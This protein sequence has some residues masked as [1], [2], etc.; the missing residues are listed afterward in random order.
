MDAIAELEPLIRSA[1]LVVAR[2]MAAVWMLPLLGRETPSRLVK[3]A[4]G[5]V[6]GVAV[7]FAL[8]AE[9]LVDPGSDPVVFGL[10]FG[11]ELMFGLL[12]G[13]VASLVF[14]VATI[15]GSIIA[16]EMGINLADQVDPT[17]RHNVPILSHL[18][19]TMAVIL[20][21]TAG[22]H[23]MV[24]GAFMRSFAAYPVGSL[25]DPQALGGFL[26][27]FTGAMVVAGIRLAAPVFLVMV[28]VTVTVGFLAKVAPQLHVLEAS[29]PIRIVAALILLVLFLPKM[30]YSF[31]DLFQKMGGGLM[32]LASGR[33]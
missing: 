7:A 21:F 24:V 22:G 25:P 31:D 18:L 29:Y 28:I 3:F 12:L 33:I 27:D 14:G 1:G 16:T 30:V 26:V 10:A 4:T 2:M 5:L 32:D 19:G 8:G 20:F 23:E 6:L 13:W 15:A 17:T 11:Q 9:R